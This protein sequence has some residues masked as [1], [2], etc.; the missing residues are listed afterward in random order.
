M[1]EKIN[2][3]L[4]G[5]KIENRQR[6]RGLDS[7]FAF[8][9]SLEKESQFVD[10]SVVEQNSTID[11]NNIIVSI[12]VENPK[13][14]N[15][16]TTTLA[17]DLVQDLKTQIVAIKANFMNEI[18]ELRFE[19]VGLKKQICDRS[20]NKNNVYDDYN[21]EILKVQNSLLQQENQFVKHEL[22]QKTVYIEKL[23]D[24]KENS[25]TNN[26]YN[27][28]ENKANLKSNRSYDFQNKKQRESI[29]QRYKSKSREQHRK[30]QSC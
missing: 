30:K 18:F 14:E 6:K 29:H 17:R 20:S 1:K 24:M 27:T 10:G 21:L 5:K 4:S 19:I 2:L 3:L 26:Y 13:I 23:L 28:D 22:Q 16:K 25:L 11:C 9:D 15:L 8:D 7:L 12:S